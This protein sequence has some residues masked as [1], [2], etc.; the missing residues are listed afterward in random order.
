M[1]LPVWRRYR[2]SGGDPV[3]ISLPPGGLSPL[4]LSAEGDRVLL[5]DYDPG[6][7]WSLHLIN[8]AIQ[9]LRQAVGPEAAWSADGKRLAFAK[10]DS[11]WVATSD[12]TEPRRVID[13]PQ[14]A[15]LCHPVVARC[16]E[17]ALHH[18][19][20]A[21]GTAEPLGSFSG[22]HQSARTSARVAPA[23]GR[24][25]RPLD[26]GR[27]V[28]RFP[29]SRPD[30]GAQG[31]TSVPPNRE[32]APAIDEQSAQAFVAAARTGTA[33]RSSPLDGHNAG[34]WSGTMPLVGSPFPTCLESRLSLPI[35]PETASGSPTSRTREACL[36]RSRRDGSARLQLTYPPL[37]PSMPRWSPD[38]KRIVFSAENQ[39]ATYSV[40]FNGGES[41]ECIKMVQSA[42][43][44]QAGLPTAPE[45]HFRATRVIGI[46][47]PGSRT[48]VPNVV[49]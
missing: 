3:S 7:L 40:P 19:A 44:M 30:L 35:F 9:R 22:R 5:S 47:R 6:N 48:P 12:G 14:P 28:L 46:W 39:S 2:I 20:D 38:G 17:A 34:S 26:G 8:G 32:P 13:H 29:V 27:P 36:W 1:L 43:A 33:N 11:L 25:E 49:P 23:I 18:V 42:W 15:N 10:D 24:R 45:W 41:S 21:S 16:N 4:G 31:G 37:Y